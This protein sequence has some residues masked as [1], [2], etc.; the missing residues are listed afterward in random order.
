ML[1]RDNI[2]L[3][4]SLKV[5][6]EN[7]IINFERV[8]ALGLV[9]LHTRGMVWLQPHD[10]EI[11]PEGVEIITNSQFLQKNPQIRLSSPFQSTKD[12]VYT[13]KCIATQK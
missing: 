4:F 8:M 9:F 10:K 12:F 2:D 11:I 7:I 13:K 6:D 5:V 1:S 3:L